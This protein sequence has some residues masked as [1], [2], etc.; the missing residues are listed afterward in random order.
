MINEISFV[1]S[2]SES[3]GS[4]ITIKCAEDV[5]PGCLAP[6]E[7]SLALEMAKNYVPPK[8][9][10]D[11]RRTTGF[12]NRNLNT[13]EIVTDVAE[14]ENGNASLRVWI[15]APRK[16][17]EH[18][19]YPAVI[20]L[21]AGSFFAGKAFMCENVCRYI[22][23]K[24][25]CTVFNVE[26]SLAPEHPYPAVLDETRLT[27]D[28]ICANAEKYNIDPENISVISESATCSVSSALAAEDKRIKKQFL[29]YPMESMFIEGMPFEW[30]LSDFEI[31][32]AQKQL[33]IPRLRLGRSDGEGDTAF[34]M[35]IAAMYLQ[36]GED[37]AD[38]KI[39]PLHGDA[40]KQCETLIFTAEFDGLRQQGE[41]YGKLLRDAGVKCEV[42]R[43]RGVHHAFMDKFGVFP[44]AKDAAD[45]IASHLSGK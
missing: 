36:H 20:Y 1:S 13:C 44:Q 24:A 28:F 19:P 12:P 17:F 11:I 29:L 40:A 35:Q 33:I 3:F 31:N 32:E 41:Y 38:P 8:G 27:L 34:M 21:H 42:I 10:E 4:P 25:P 2:R 7:L 5:V 6:C 18:E 16:P 30:K 43:Y 45:E 26:Y 22:A 39:S 37:R 15:Y 23:E 14:I 9:I